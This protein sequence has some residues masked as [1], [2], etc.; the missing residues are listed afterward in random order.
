MFLDPCGY[1]FDRAPTVRSRRYFRWLVGPGGDAGEDDPEDDP[2][3]EVSELWEARW[4]RVGTF[5]T[6]GDD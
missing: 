1:L 6:A 4:R 5:P 2:D 3:D